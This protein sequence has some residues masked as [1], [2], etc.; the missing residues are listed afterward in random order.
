MVQDGTNSILKS[1]FDYAN[2]FEIR[3]QNMIEDNTNKFTPE[4][5]VVCEV[6]PV[7]KKTRR[8]SLR[9]SCIMTT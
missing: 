3:L 6:P 8:Q 7:A 2:E 1:K 9:L 4:M 5:I